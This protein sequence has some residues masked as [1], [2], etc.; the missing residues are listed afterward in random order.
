M[1]GGDNFVLKKTQKMVVNQK[2]EAWF[3]MVFNTFFFRMTLVMKQGTSFGGFTA[4][5]CF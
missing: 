3:K 2:L 5:A 1:I 4:Q